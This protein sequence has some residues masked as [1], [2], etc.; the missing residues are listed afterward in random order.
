MRHSRNETGLTGS[1]PFF[2]QVMLQKFENE[3]DI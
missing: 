1:L 2:G 3:K